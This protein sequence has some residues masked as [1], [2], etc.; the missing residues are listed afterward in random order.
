MRRA[1]FAMDQERRLIAFGLES[2]FFGNAREFQGGQRFCRRPMEF[3]SI[4]AAA[5]TMQPP[6]R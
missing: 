5:W 1:S 2:N 3:S 4:H 6:E